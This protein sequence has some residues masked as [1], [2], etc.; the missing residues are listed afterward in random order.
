MIFILWYN[1]T[2]YVSL[3]AGVYCSIATRLCMTDPPPTHRFKM[4][5]SNYVL[6]S[7][8]LIAA[9]YYKILPWIWLFPILSSFSMDFTLRLQLSELSWSNCI[10]VS[11]WDKQGLKSKHNQIYK[12]N[13]LAQLQTLYGSIDSCVLLPTCGRS[14]NSNNRFSP[15]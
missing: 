8:C 9:P 13:I 6:N 11:N 15:T 14:T 5:N 3:M 12:K 2:L 10:N 4:K 1:C 7:H